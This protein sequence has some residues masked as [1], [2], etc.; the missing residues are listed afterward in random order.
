MRWESPKSCRIWEHTNKLS[1]R[2]LEFDA[3][4]MMKEMD[5]LKEP[6]ANGKKSFAVHLDA[7]IANNF[8]PEHLSRILDKIPYENAVFA[9]QKGQSNMKLVVPKNEV[10]QLRQQQDNMDKSK[11][12]EKPSVMATLDANEEK[13]QRQSALGK[14]VLTKK[15]NGMEI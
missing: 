12:G 3:N 15:K 11:K 6:N 7:Y 5:G 9:V 8:S 1:D 10:L 14:D 13:V 2:R 4:K